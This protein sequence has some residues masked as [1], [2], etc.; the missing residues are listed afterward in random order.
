[1]GRKGREAVSLAKLGW[2]WRIGSVAFLLYALSQSYLAM[3]S[4]TQSQKAAIALALDIS[5]QPVSLL[6]LDKRECKDGYFVTSG[7]L[8]KTRYPMS[9][10]IENESA[11]FLGMLIYT[12]ENIPERLVWRTTIED[13]LSPASRRY[14]KQ[15]IDFVIEADCDVIFTVDTRHESPLTGRVREMRWGPYYPSPVLSLDAFRIP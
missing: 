7:I 8:V 11:K 6:A 2:A 4:Y 13:D 5:I 15:S 10:D 9:D 1:M 3:R 14:G 12:V